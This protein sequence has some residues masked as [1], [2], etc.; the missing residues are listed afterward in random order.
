MITTGYHLLGTVFGCMDHSSFYFMCALVHFA[1]SRA[2]M[3]DV[4]NSQLSCCHGHFPN[5]CV[6]FSLI[7]TT[8]FI[9]DSCPRHFILSLRCH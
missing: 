1:Q 3:D 2:D 9:V 4:T 8:S 5:F 7:I 6:S